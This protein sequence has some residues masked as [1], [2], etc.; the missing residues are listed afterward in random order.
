MDTKRTKFL[1]CILE[2]IEKL[3][4]QHGGSNKQIVKL[5]NKFY[6]LS[7]QIKKSKSAQ[8]PLQNKKLHKPK[9]TK[10]LLSNFQISKNIKYLTHDFSGEFN[11]NIFIKEVK[12]DLEKIFRENKNIPEPLET[13][14][15]HFVFKPKPKWWRWEKGKKKEYD[16]GWSSAKVENW[17][18][19]VMGEGTHPF[20]NDLLYNE[21][22][23]PFK[24][25]IEIRIGELYNIFSYIDIRYPE[26]NID[27]DNN[28]KNANFYT[29]VDM[30]INSLLRIFKGILEHAQ[31]K[32]LYKVSVSFGGN[33]IK[34]VHHNSEVL[35]THKNILK[36]DFLEIKDKTLKSLCNWSIEAVFTDGTYRFNILDDKNKPEYEKINYKIKGF[37]HILS[38]Y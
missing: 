10:L 7:C 16:V 13:R 11:Y 25:T 34:I 2:D 1:M 30:L 14:I 31:A 12:K 5:K 37:T 24:H 3:E 23:E 27:L 36:G 6:D 20:N 9:E 33:R 8:L 17:C 21:F 22:I 38:F 4:K 29:D 18:T 15:R 26:L 19:S 35:K 32:N 28:L